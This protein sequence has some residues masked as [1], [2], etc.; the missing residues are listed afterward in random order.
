MTETHYITIEK[1][2]N[3]IGLLEGIKENT[4]ETKTDIS[5][6]K[7]DAPDSLFEKYEQLAREIAEIKATLSELK[8]KFT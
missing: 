6:P 7:K 5:A 3:A 2:G 8:A 1:Q 4:S